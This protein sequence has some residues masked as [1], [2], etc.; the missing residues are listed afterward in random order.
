M[1]WAVAVTHPDHNSL[2][3]YREDLLSL[4]HY[5]LIYQSSVLFCFCS[6][7]LLE[8]SWAL[9]DD[10][11]ELIVFR[12]DKVMVKSHGFRRNNSWVE[13]FSILIPR[14][15]RLGARMFEEMR[16]FNGID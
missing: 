13:D 11:G 15:V 10:P 2:V 8:P 1:H 3:R 6:L 16:K 7:F 4:C 14:R 9:Q 12:F 5:V